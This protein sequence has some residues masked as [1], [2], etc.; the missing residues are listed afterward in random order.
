MQQDHQRREQPRHQADET[1]VMWT[2][3]R[4]MNWHT[5]S[6]APEFRP[7]DQVLTLDQAAES[8]RTRRVKAGIGSLTS[9]SA[10]FGPARPVYLGNP[11]L[12]ACLVWDSTG[13]RSGPVWASD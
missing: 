9:F 4:R 12:N 11:G 13:T 1:I 5:I 6:F 3:I 8:C 7:L 2:R 10:A